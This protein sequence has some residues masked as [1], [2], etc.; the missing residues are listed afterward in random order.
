MMQEEIRPRPQLNNRRLWTW[1]ALVVALCLGGAAG[2]LL[3]PA[4]MGSAT[5]W[6]MSLVYQ[7]RFIDVVSREYL[8][9]GDTDYLNWLLDG[10]EKEK[11]TALLVDMEANAD[12]PAKEQR[13]KALREA[14]SI[15]SAEPSFWQLMRRQPMIM[16]LGLAAGVILLLAGVLGMFLAT[17]EDRVRQ[18]IE[19]AIFV[20]A[21][22][23][24]AVTQAPAPLPLRAANED[25]ERGA[26]FSPADPNPADRR[27]RARPASEA[28]TA[29]ESPA[30]PANGGQQP[31]QSTPQTAAQTQAQPV[32][33]A[34]NIP[35]NPAAQP[36]QPATAQQGGQQPQ[37]AAQAAPVAAPKPE[38]APPPL[39]DEKELTADGTSIGD[40]IADVFD[41]SDEQLHQEALLKGLGP[42]DLDD[43]LKLLY[44]V[45][46]DLRA[47][48]LQATG[49]VTAEKNRQEAMIR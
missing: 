29:E 11:I 6:E 44:Q 39:V 18:V 45:K 49:L 35:Q 31:E 17:E 20:Q 43:L 36:A 21:Q 28:E 40:L 24:T 34:A 14:L 41:D 46:N 22:A 27:R 33:L 25:Q 19:Q 42:V 26:V 3:R 7:E 37:Q 2:F 30:Q 1:L 10:W 15:P 4:Q 47:G 5:P 38:D 16:F 48:G 12:G 9:N 32:A 13:L 23:Y 8:A